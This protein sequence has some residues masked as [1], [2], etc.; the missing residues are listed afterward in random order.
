M[1]DWNAFVRRQIESGASVDPSTD[2]TGIARY[3]ALP[4]EYDALCSGLALVCRAD[5]GLLE[6]AGA[7]RSGWLH[8]LVTN[9]VKTLGCAEGVYA[10]ALDLKGRIQFD[11][12]ILVDNESI[13]LDLDRGFLPAAL[14]HFEKY[15]VIEEVAV[16]DRSGDSVRFALVGD[17]AKALLGELG[18]PHA[19]ALPLLSTTTLTWD[20]VAIPMFRSDFCGC[21]AVEWMVPA[22]LAV[23][24]WRGL[25][26][27]ARARPAVPV[28]GEAVH[29]R[30]IEAGM[31]WPGQEITDEVVPAETMQLDRAVSFQKGCYLGQEIVERM[32]SRGVVARR[33]VGLRFARGATPA[34]GALLHDPD[35]KPVGR[36]TS[37][38]HRVHTEESIGLGYAASAAA[39]SGTE[40]TVRWDG[41]S[42]GAVVA[43]L[44]FIRTS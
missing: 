12:N 19:A 1:S 24:V 25:V 38:C 7:D 22:Q 15:T 6:V 13:R 4:Q 40:L 2:A 9:Q 5:R 23:E 33:L 30:R 18:A 34:S 29:I 14:K 28:G 26:D 42:A 21:F 36:V 44:P 37:S 35:G 3:G 41:R 10:F 39:A 27:A 43:D 8:N 17:G 31:P 20:G 11:M 16:A 32:R